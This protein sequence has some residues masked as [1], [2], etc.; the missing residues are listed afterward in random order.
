MKDFANYYDLFYYQGKLGQAIK[1]IRINQLSNSCK[2]GLTF[3][4]M[5]Q[6]LTLK[7]LSQNYL[8]NSFSVPLFRLHHKYSFNRIWSLCSRLKI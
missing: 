1:L 4:N 3:D 7:I 8:E 2:V 5:K 6:S